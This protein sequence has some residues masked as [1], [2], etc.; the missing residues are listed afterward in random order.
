MTDR[1][2]TYRIIGQYYADHLEE[3]RAFTE[4]RVGQREVAEDMVQDVFKRLLSSD[5]LITEVTLPCLVHTALRHAATDYW[6]HRRAVREFERYLSYRSDVL[7]AS[8]PAT[9]YSAK[10]INTILEQGVQRLTVQQQRIYRM[11]IF[12][13]MPVSEI[14]KTLDIN[15]KR[16]ENHLGAAR[17]QVR[18]YVKS[19]LA[20]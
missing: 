11:S 20:V 15:Y 7:S 16:A 8:S 14:S 2:H 3:L 10:E 1:K 12:D 6:R 4:S 17:R 9:V 19:R 13:G 5:K 18:L